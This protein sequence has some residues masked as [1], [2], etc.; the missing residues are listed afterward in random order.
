MHSD[1]LFVLLQHLRHHRWFQRHIQPRRISTLTCLILTTSRVRI[2]YRAVNFAT[3]LAKELSELWVVEQREVHPKHSAVGRVL[4]VH[5]CD[6]ARDDG[7]RARSNLRLGAEPQTVRGDKKLP[8]NHALQRARKAIESNAAGNHVEHTR[9]RG[10][11]APTLSITARG[12][13]IVRRVFEKAPSEHHGQANELLAMCCLRSAGPRR[14]ACG[15]KRAAKCVLCASGHIKKKHVRRRLESLLHSTRAVP[16]PDDEEAEQGDLHNAQL[17][18]GAHRRCPSC[19]G[20]RQRAQQPRQQLLRLRLPFLHRN[21]HT[22]L[23]RRLS[24]R[25]EERFEKASRAPRQR[26]ERVCRRLAASTARN[27]ER[28]VYDS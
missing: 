21:P 11:N 25:R 5:V 9:A 12:H 1:H 26:H 6:E 15:G 14:A 8:L 20:A 23:A 22:N 19:R 17:L 27:G 28:F 18:R 10:F 24:A 7:C 4:L 16:V 2:N 3:E 13:I